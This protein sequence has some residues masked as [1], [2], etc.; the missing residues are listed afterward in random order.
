MNSTNEMKI[1][2]DYIRK[3]VKRT[4]ND[5]YLN[6]Y[7]VKNRLSVRIVKWDKREH[8]V[9][10]CVRDLKHP[11][12]KWNNYYIH[13]DWIRTCG[14]FWRYNIWRAVNDIVCNMRCEDRL[15]F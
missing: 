15:P 14:H 12:V 4:K 9:L 10:I 11:E 3:L 5:P 6:E 7:D 1:V 2:R 13:W 8:R